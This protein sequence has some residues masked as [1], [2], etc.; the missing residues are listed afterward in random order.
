MPSP[1]QEGPRGAC[2]FSPGVWEELGTSMKSFSPGKK[3]KKVQSCKKALLVRSGHIHANPSEP[4]PIRHPRD[5]DAGLLPPASPGGSPVSTFCLRFR[6]QRLPHPGKRCRLFADRL[7]FATVFSSL[8][9]GWDVLLCPTRRGADRRAARVCRTPHL[10]RG[11]R[12]SLQARF[13]PGAPA[14]PPG[15]VPDSGP[16]TLV[17]LCLHQFPWGLGCPLQASSAGLST[18]EPAAA[19][20]SEL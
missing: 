14:R 2:C 13:Q 6:Q 3:K 18:C 17:L 11:R 20:T 15:A 4:R 12:S 16:G 19:V 8:G 1:H 7:V 10:W 5:A 9:S